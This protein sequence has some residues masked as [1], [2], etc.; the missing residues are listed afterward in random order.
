M[1]EKISI[2]LSKDQALVL[3]EFLSCFNDTEQ[4]EV[5]NHISEQKILWLI[6]GQLEKLLVEPFDPNYEKLLFDARNRVND[7]M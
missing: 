3:F 4:K 6:E 1:S 2:E 7:V 5:F